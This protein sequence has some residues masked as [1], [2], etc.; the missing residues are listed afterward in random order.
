M[1]LVVAMSVLAGPVACRS[2]LQIRLFVALCLPMR[3]LV[4]VEFLVPMQPVAAESV[5]LMQLVVAESV[6]M[7]R[8]V[9]ESVLPMRLCVAVE[10]LLPIGPVACRSSLLVLVEPP[11]RPSLLPGLP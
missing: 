3:L 10:F 5:F 8:V 7:G 2:V 11:R 1:R 4:A 6:S 9:P